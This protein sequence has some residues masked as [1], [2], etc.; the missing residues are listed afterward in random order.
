MK[1]TQPPLY[2]YACAT[3][4][5]ATP[6]GIP[7]DIRE[8][9]VWAGDDPLV[10]SRPGLFSPEPIGPRFPRRTVAPEAASVI[11]DAWRAW[12]MH[13]PAGPDGRHQRAPSVLAR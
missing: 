1:K 2:V 8:G 13:R 7:V 9:D 12:L 6:D 3:C 11:D 10:L 5:A 4:A